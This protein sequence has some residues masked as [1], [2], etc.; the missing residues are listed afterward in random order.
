M[1]LTLSRR[2]QRLAAFVGAG[3]VA[4]LA[5]TGCI[6][7]DA[8][9]AIASDATAS[10]T[11]A[12]ELQKDAAGFL[13][14]S[15]LASFQ[16]QIDEGALTEGDELETF[17]ECVTSESETG[18]VYTCSFANMPFTEPSGLWTV[19]KEESTI[20]FAMTSEGAGEETQGADN[21]L[22]DAS[23]GS[24]NVT[25]EFPGPITAVE[26]EFV[27]QTSESTAKVSAAMTETINVTIRSEDG[28][29]GTNIA[30]IIVIALA[31]GVAV[32]LIVAVVLLVMRRRAG[33]QEL[34]LPAAGEAQEAESGTEIAAA[35]TDAAPPALP[36][37]DSD[38]DEPRQPGAGS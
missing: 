22:G 21:L 14:I 34:A 24:I 19:T 23:M 28:S 7:V 9:V 37:A 31:A 26:G 20:V 38:E 5:L 32:L 2:P 11:F 35:E 30:V 29:S 10:G 12:F 13:G 36:P 8:N 3:I 4:S 16:S 6:K 25:V 15:D 18:Y 33:T 17:Q 1:M 27:E